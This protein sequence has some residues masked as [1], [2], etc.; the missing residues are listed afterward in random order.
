MSFVTTQPEALATA[1]GELQA[2]GA[3]MI[4]GNEAAAAPTTTV[5][6]A[7]ADIVSVLTAAQ[8]AA[9]AQLYQAIGAQAA[10]VQELFATTLGASAG[11]YAATEA[12][13][14]ST[15]N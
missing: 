8:F 14:N 3:A 12:L 6:P 13:N 9:H 11:S 4:A 1:A 7:A 5:V 15:L 2:I 10:A